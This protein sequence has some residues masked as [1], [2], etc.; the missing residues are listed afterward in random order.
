MISSLCQICM[1]RFVRAALFLAGT[2]FALS[3]FAQQYPP[4]S[5]NELGYT[6]RYW[7]VDEDLPNSHINSVGQ[8]GDG[9]VWVATRGG[10]ARLDGQ[11]AK[12]Y[13]VADILG[14]DVRS[15]DAFNL[16]CVDSRGR[17]WFGIIP[18][19]LVCYEAGQFTVFGAEHDCPM[20]TWLRLTEGP[21]GVMWGT[22]DVNGDHQDYRIENDRFEPG[23]AENIDYLFTGVPGRAHVLSN[24]IL[25]QLPGAANSEDLPEASSS[26]QLYGVFLSPHPTVVQDWRETN[27]Q[28]FSLYRFALRCKRQR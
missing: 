21:G 17:L 13:H 16:L 12:S 24:P 4:I 6:A 3:G 27:F 7:S 9:Y 14:P 11:S 20:G 18:H 19:R 1:S 28:S 8:S 2:C 23:T 26:L 5:L 22:V 25:P 10:L 15:R